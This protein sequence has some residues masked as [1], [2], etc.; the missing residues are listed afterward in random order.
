M[1]NLCIRY[2]IVDQ[3][4]VIV[5]QEQKYKKLEQWSN[6]FEDQNEN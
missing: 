4:Q 6:I 1:I 5:A 2:N 3:S